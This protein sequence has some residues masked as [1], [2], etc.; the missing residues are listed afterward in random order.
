MD[1]PPF[2]VNLIE[3]LTSEHSEKIKLQAKCDNELESEILK[4]DEI[5][6]STIE[7]ASSPSS[8][9]QEPTSL[10]PPSIESSPS[11]ELK[12]FPKHLKYAYLG[13]LETLKVIIASNLTNRQE[14]NL[15]TI[16]RNRGKPLVG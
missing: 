16:L 13:E 12:A 11:L 9:D 14:E 1:D 15:M 10:I 5:V 7:W 3:D 8:L 6:N 4:L 2:E